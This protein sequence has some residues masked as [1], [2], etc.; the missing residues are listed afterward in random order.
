[1]DVMDYRPKKKNISLGELLRI[2]S[3]EDEN[4]ALS[5]PNASITA[6]ISI[7]R[8]AVFL[9]VVLPDGSE[10]LHLLSPLLAHFSGREY[11]IYYKRQNSIFRTSL[12]IFVN[13][14]MS[15]EQ[16]PTWDDY[17][18]IRFDRGEQLQQIAW[19][20]PLFE[21]EDSGDLRHSMKVRQTVDGAKHTYFLNVRND[22]M[23]QTYP[24]LWHAIWGNNQ[25][26][27]HPAFFNVDVYDSLTL[28]PLDRMF[29]SDIPPVANPLQVCG[30]G[31]VGKTHTVINALSRQFVHAKVIDSHC[32]LF[33]YVIFITAKRTMLNTDKPG[34]TYMHWENADFQTCDSAL[35]RILRIITDGRPRYGMSPVDEEDFDQ[36]VPLM[37]RQIRNC[38][39]NDP[40][41]L[42]VD[43]LDSVRSADA[44]LSGEAKRNAD[45]DEQCRLV[46]ALTL[47]TQNNDNCRIIITT[48]RPLDEVRKLQLTPLS[49]EIALN[50]ASAY[51]RRSRPGDILPEPYKAA[52]E[53]IGNGIPAFIMRIVYLLNRSTS[54][55]LDSAQMQ[56]LQHDIA[57]FSL[58][59]T[60]LDMVGI[61]AFSILA[62]MSNVFDALPVGL[63]KILLYDEMLESIND[64]IDEM[65]SWSMIEKR[66][67]S[68]RVAL[69]SDSLILWSQLD[70]YASLDQRHQDVLNAVRQDNDR[71]LLDY[72]VHPGILMEKVFEMLNRDMDAMSKKKF[73][74]RIQELID[75]RD[76]F[77]QGMQ[78]NPEERKN[79]DTWISIFS[80]DTDINSTHEQTKVPLTKAGISV[81]MLDV[82]VRPLLDA[83]QYG[84]WDAETVVALV[85]SFE[86]MDFSLSE[87]QELFL[88]LVRFL[89]EK[90]KNAIQERKYSS[91][92][93]D[94]LITRLDTL[95]GLYDKQTGERSSEKYLEPYIIW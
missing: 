35:S 46:E 15:E 3:D 72:M 62:Q 87:T 68:E 49:P 83:L 55:S 91:S 2:L 70:E 82:K 50:F 33:K 27:T 19:D 44:S 76:A 28:V 13:S 67:N 18:Q 24:E 80:K 34:A 37:V 47:L 9:H 69:Q 30:Q 79:V 16:I 36:S 8:N 39:G 48:R 90:L 26:T 92:D 58:N 66:G 41:L 20:S 5:G 56:K 52:V 61:M 42:I 29:R 17:Q 95:C 6:P 45:R 88:Q 31:G 53:K 85:A 63:L 65:Q 25:D 86:A 75:K 74:R 43:D 64:A 4:Q 81:K 60:T 23:H 22:R 1:M 59:T 38:L 11:G 73:A 84:S 40:M 51:F 89:P 57:D 71:W 78:N 14:R 77:F 7:H 93:A 94:V 54:Y 12:Y 10:R 32:L 21:N